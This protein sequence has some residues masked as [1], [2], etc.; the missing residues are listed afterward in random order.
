MGIRPG[1]NSTSSAKVQLDRNVDKQWCIIYYC[2]N[3]SQLAV[4]NLGALVPNEMAPLC[5]AQS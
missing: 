3:A 2:I 5:H 4:L 1:L